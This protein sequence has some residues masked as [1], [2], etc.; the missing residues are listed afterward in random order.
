[1]GPVTLGN[2]VS[3]VGEVS[4]P[5]VS[6]IISLLQ[7]FRAD[8]LS[9]RHHQYPIPFSS[10]FSSIPRFNMHLSCGSF[11]GLFTAFCFRRPGFVFTHRV[12]TTDRRSCWHWF[13]IS[14]YLH[15][16]RSLYFHIC[17]IHP[18]GGKDGK[19]KRILWVDRTRLRK[20]M[21]KKG[22]QEP[23]VFKEGCEGSGL[24]FVCPVLN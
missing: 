17:G 8:S 3:C 7:M 9:H 22:R 15:S 4:I 18:G 14:A 21:K 23:Y 2:W 12:G 20:R 6:N 13:F 10:D 19:E 5:F 11:S 16:R 24:S 1:M